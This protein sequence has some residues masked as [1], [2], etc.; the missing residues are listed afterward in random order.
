[1]H[2][3][4]AF[5]MLTPIVF[6]SF[7]FQNESEEICRRLVKSVNTSVNVRHYEL[8]KLSE[9]K[10]LREPIDASHASRNESTRYVNTDRVLFKLGNPNVTYNLLPDD[11]DI[12][13]ADREVVDVSVDLIVSHFTSLDSIQILQSEVETF[14]AEGLLSLEWVDSRINNKDKLKTIGLQQRPRDT[15]RKPY[16][17]EISFYIGAPYESPLWMPALYSP[18]IMNMTLGGQG[19]IRVSLQETETIQ[20][21]TGVRLVFECRAQPAYYPYDQLYCDLLINSRNGVK[22]KWKRAAFQSSNDLTNKFTIRNGS[23]LLTSV[24]TINPCEKLVAEL[25]GETS[26]LNIHFHI[27]RHMP[28]FE[29]SFYAPT[30]FLVILSYSTLYL[31]EDS[32]TLRIMVN[33]SV[34]AMLITCYFWM[35]VIVHNTPTTAVDVLTPVEIWLFCCTLFTFAIL[36]QFIIYVGKVSFDRFYTEWYFNIEHGLE[37]LKMY[38]AKWEEAR[39]SP[40]LSFFRWVA[41]KVCFLFVFSKDD[42][43]LDII[44]RFAYLGLMIAFM[45]SFHTIYIPKLKNEMEVYETGDHQHIVPS[46]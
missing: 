26:C 27:L 45:V 1:M 46:Q 10:E 9:L 29:F 13:R 32:Y 14:A 17:K 24:D 18:N 7:Q 5:L 16:T 28:Y 19:L 34:I 25:D 30:S 42:L 20:Y 8:Y 36:L 37:R 11:Y 43:L 22:L 2:S 33:A 12:L 38:D 4:V 35:D 21:S 41:L 23:F 6:N 15:F 44:S 31:G 3:I 40:A 39:R